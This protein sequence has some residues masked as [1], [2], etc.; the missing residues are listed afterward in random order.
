MQAAT[1]SGLCA[2]LILDAGQNIQEPE[3]FSLHDTTPTAISAT[4]GWRQPQLPACSAEAAQ[5]QIK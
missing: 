5:R 3:T 1:F 2:V 4:L